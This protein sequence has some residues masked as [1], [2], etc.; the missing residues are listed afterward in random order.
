MRIHLRPQRFHLQF[1]HLLFLLV[2]KRINGIKRKAA[3]QQ[4]MS[5]LEMKALRAQMNP[6]FI[7][8]SL[9]SIQE[10][11]ISN[12]TEAASK[13]L[14]KFSKLIRMVLENSGKKFISLQDE[15][16]YLQLYLEL[17]S[18][19]FDDLN[20]TIS[21]NESDTAFIRIPPMIVQPYVENALKHGLAHKAGEKKLSVLFYHNK[22]NQLTAEIT[23]NGIGRKQSMLINTSRTDAH[24]SMGMQI[25]QQRLSLLNE[26]Q[27]ASVEI[28]DLSEENGSAAGTKV[29]VILPT[30]Q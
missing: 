26:E 15:I 6:H 13:Y 30:E 18:F 23:D 22:K 28:T 14:G 4:Q 1:A 2:R 24:Q 21:C 11:I 10:S 7:F 29:T 20:F 16:N 17:E 8:N 27:Q 25:T 19:R 12:K 5:E 3:L 9:S